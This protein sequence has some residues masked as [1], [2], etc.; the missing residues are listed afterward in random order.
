MRHARLK[1]KPKGSEIA[2][3]TVIKVKGITRRWIF[4]TML[5]I[6]S[7]VLVTIV[8]FG[9]FIYSYYC[10]LAKST[11]DSYARFFTGLSYSTLDKFTDNAHDYIERFQQKDLMRV[12]IID[13]MG[14]IVADTDGYVTQNV[15]MPDYY[16]ARNSTSGTGSYRGQLDTGERVMS[17]TFMLSDVGNGV[18]GAVRWIISMTPIYYKFAFSMVLALCFGAII[19]IITLYSG[20]YF[21]K[22]IVIPVR[23]VSSTARRIAMGDFKARM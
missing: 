23:E 6:A 13:N 18:N 17:Q 4:N 12:Q 9:F 21:N 22:S 15:A 20:R 1:T 8:A 3:E 16:T 14:N 2:M 5:T 10:N 7:A 11:A 19:I